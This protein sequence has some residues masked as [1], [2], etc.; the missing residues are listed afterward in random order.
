MRNLIVVYIYDCYDFIN[1]LY[2]IENIVVI[3]SYGEKLLKL[4]MKFIYF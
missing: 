2:G 1:I 4:N 3:Y